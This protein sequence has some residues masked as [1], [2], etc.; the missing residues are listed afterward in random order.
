MTATTANGAGALSVRFVAY[1]SNAPADSTVYD[2]GSA[3]RV[4]NVP[5]GD[6]TLSIKT[7]IKDAYN[8]YGAV[9]NTWEIPVCTAAGLTA[10]KGNPST[11]APGGCGG[12]GN[13][14]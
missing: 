8:R 10:S 13:E 6:Y 1:Y 3:T 7:R 11:T 14:N 2:W 9:V 12:G 4:I 5:A